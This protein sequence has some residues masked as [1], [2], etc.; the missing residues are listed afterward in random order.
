MRKIGTF[1]PMFDVKPIKLSGFYRM[2]RADFW[3]KKS[4]F[5]G[6][7]STKAVQI[8]NFCRTDSQQKPYEKRKSEGK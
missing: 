1:A 7:T 2:T 8:V 3:L 6:K 4:T 5:S